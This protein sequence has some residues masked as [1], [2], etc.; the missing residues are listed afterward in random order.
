MMIQ[1]KAVCLSKQTHQQEKCTAINS[2]GVSFQVYR[3]PRQQCN[4][5]APELLQLGCELVRLYFNLASKLAQYILTQQ[6]TALTVVTVDAFETS[7]KPLGQAKGITLMIEPLTVTLVLVL[8]H[9]AR[10]SCR[11][12][13]NV[14]TVILC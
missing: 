10:A 12:S 2:R 8:A 1:I 4:T 6:P 11:I 14:Y 3:R 7:A 5:A 13:H 9:V